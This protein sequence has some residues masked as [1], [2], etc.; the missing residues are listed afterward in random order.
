MSAKCT[1]FILPVFLGFLCYLLFLGGQNESDVLRDKK[2]VNDPLTN[3]ASNVN[4]SNHPLEDSYCCCTM[5]EIISGTE[6]IASL[7]NNITS[8]PFFRYFKVNV[9]KP[10]P[11]WAVQLLCIS[12]EN[13]CQVCSCD[14]NDVPEALK[15]PHDMSDPSVV[16]SRVSY[17]GEKHPNMDLWG[18]WKDSDSEATY[19]DLLQN[20]EAN[21][22]YSGPMASRVWQAIYKENCMTEVNQEG[23]STEEK[24]CKEVQVFR[25]LISGLQTSITMHVAA[26]F[27]KDKEGKSPLIALGLLKNP[28]MSFLPNCGMYQRI[29]KSQEYIDNLYVL[30]QFILRALAKA[31]NVFLL[32][33]NAFNSGEGGKA[34]DEDKELHKELQELFNEHLLCSSTF[35]EARFLESPMARKLIPQM[36]RM[37]LNITTLMD[38]VACEKCRVWGKLETMGLATAFKILMLSSGDTLKL[39]R[40]EEVSLVNFARQLAIS[41]KSVHSLAT[42]C[43]EL[44]GAQKK[45]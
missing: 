20:P 11:Y 4:H 2:T 28:N 5:E 15:Y 23:D 13:S 21:T 26:F 41:V 7:L 14:A 16:E 17:E 43:K 18:V 12:E 40:G 1:W 30:Y 6:V 27:H 44:E 24:E 36:N 19:V 45:S 31:K 42:V 33:L 35:D 10:C 37:M 34:T 25:K 22:G 9:D 8:R 3:Q 39:S 32:D 38:C 29:T